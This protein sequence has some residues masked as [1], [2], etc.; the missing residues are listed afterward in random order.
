MTKGKT[1]SPYCGGGYN[2]PIDRLGV[3]IGAVLGI[4][5]NIVLPG[6]KFEFGQKTEAKEEA[7]A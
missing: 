6:K 2:V 1:R 7:G 4:F 3:A 5:L